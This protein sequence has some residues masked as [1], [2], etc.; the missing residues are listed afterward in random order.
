MALQLCGFLIEWGCGND[1]EVVGYHVWA[2]APSGVGPGHQ[3]DCERNSLVWIGHRAQRRG[4]SHDADCRLHPYSLL[5]RHSGGATRA[6]GFMTEVR[7]LDH[8][9]VLHSDLQQARQVYEM[10]GFN[11]GPVR[12]HVELGSSNCIVYLD[13][14]YLELIDFGESADWL[15]APYQD[16]IACGSG[17][18]H[19]SIRSFDLVKDRARMLANGH[20][21]DDILSARRKVVLPGGHEDETASSCFY[22]WRKDNLYLSLFLTEHEKPETIFVPEYVDHPN[23]AVEVSRLVY[24]SNR[25]GDDADYFCSL[26][27]KGLQT[28]SE[29]GFSIVGRR[30]EVT[31]VLT[32]GAARERYG[33]ALIR[34]ESS[35]LDG[36]AA[37]IHFQVSSLNRCKRLLRE[38]GTAVAEKQRS[39]MVPA[40]V[41]SGVVMV[42]EQ[43]QP[44]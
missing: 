32:P 11:V 31:E 33:S 10:L 44:L 37:A 5:H 21:P 25:P 26:F 41:G 30:G 18:P 40:S 6:L 36:F 35:P 9:I 3:Y 8:F 27:G 1:G 38:N 14:T 19:V 7:S 29:S 12:R 39:I 4:G 34:P 43:V 22:V 42:F 15:S 24:M 23:S 17:I 20:N 28:N 16:F 13:Q 2:N